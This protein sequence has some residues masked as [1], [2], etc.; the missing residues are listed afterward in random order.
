[1]SANF[2]LT[3]I[4]EGIKLFHRKKTEWG[5]QMRPDGYGKECEENYGSKTW[6]SINQQR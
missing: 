2:A 1:M 5:R 6:Q 4:L 3:S